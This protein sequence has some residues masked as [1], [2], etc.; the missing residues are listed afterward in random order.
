MTAIEKLWGGIQ[1][2]WWHLVGLGP[3]ALAI[4]AGLTVVIVVVAIAIQRLARWLMCQ[5]LSRLPDESKAERALR[6]RKALQFTG[7]VVGLLVTGISAVMIADLWGFDVMTWASQGSGQKIASTFMRLLTVV[8]ITAIAL[9]AVGLFARSTL[10]GLKRRSTD[11]RRAAQ[12]D[13]LGP[14]VRRVLQV[15]II[16]LAA[17]TVL[18]QIG[19]Q[20]AP[21]LSAAGVVG[22]AVGF[23]AQSLVKDFFT[24]LFLL[25]EDIVAIGDVVQ[26][27][28]F[29]G[30][31]E[32]MTLRTIRLRDADGTLHIF[33]YGESQIIHNMTKTFSF[34]AMD[35]VVKPDTDLDKAMDVMRQTAAELR[36]DPDYGPLIDADMEI[37][38]IDLL[39]D[40]GIVI[41]GRIRTIPNDRWKVLRA[42]NLRIKQAFDAAGIALS[43]K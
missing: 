6:A 24:G 13:T 40:V 17:M 15:I 39:S 37:A 42:Y 32:D 38:G 19:V 36:K 9:E 31:V 41:K 25:V 20:I 18:S 1:T 5:G 14:I 12:L 43:H 7:W 3:V 21:I 11:P 27:Q 34:A 26:I 2:W 16:V 35:L 10:Q 4:N 30:E 8:V 29:S 33:P 23:G 28:S 22:I